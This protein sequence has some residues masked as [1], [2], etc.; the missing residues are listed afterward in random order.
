MPLTGCSRPGAILINDW[1]S[2][3]TAELL[4]TLAETG[5]K[6]VKLSPRSPNLN[7]YARMIVPGED[8]LRIAVREF[9]AH[10]RERNRQG[11]GNVFIFREPSPI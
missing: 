9:V 4:S 8:A 1:D 2:L 3:F 6:S 11:I 10:H 7:S 5:I